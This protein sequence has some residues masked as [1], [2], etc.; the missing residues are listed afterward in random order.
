MTAT[1][2]S[3]SRPLS[4]S[5]GTKPGKRADVLHP[6]GPGRG[7]EIRQVR[8]LPGHHGP[9]P[10]HGLADLGQ[11]VDEGLEA[12]LVLHPPPRHEQR[13]VAAAPAPPTVVGRRPLRGVDAV[14]HHVH[15]VAGQLERVHHL[16]AHELRA[17]DDPGGLVGQPP[18]DA[19]DGRRLARPEVTPA[20][21]PFG[22]V[23]RGH[24]RHAPPGPQGL[25][26]PRHQPVVGVH[27]VRS[28]VPEAGGQRHQ[29]VV[30]AGHAGHE[31]VVG[32]PG[33][34]GHAPAAPG[35]RR[36]RHRQGRRGGAA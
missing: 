23:D 34:L 16:V 25:P 30:G 26:G 18:L 19:V 5:S 28:P 12:L 6:H 32:Q 35:P 10:R 2:A 20:A 15:L 29:V 27:D 13:L 1:V 36:P 9:H 11:R 24:Q 8:T 22:G 3:W 7:V 14:R 33:E 31:L 4:S 17:A 21:S